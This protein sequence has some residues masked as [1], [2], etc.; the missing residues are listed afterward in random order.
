VNWITPSINAIEP[1]QIA[2]GFFGLIHG[3]I[4]PLEKVVLVGQVT[5]KNDYA[6]AGG[7]AMFNGGAGLPFVLD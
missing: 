2:P 3:H 4:R 7:T 6:D 1:N 5:G